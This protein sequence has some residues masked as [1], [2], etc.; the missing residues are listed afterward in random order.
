M[1]RD[2][3]CQ[4]NSCTVSHWLAGSGPWP[5]TRGRVVMAT[6]TLTVCIW[7]RPAHRAWTMAQNLYGPRVRMGNWN[8]DVYLEEVC[9]TWRGAPPRL[10]RD[11]TPTPTLSSPFSPAHTEYPYN[12]TPHRLLRNLTCGSSNPGLCPSILPGAPWAPKLG[13][14]ALKRR[15]ACASPQPRLWSHWVPSAL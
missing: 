13:A 7:G 3:H 12:P 10:L 5:I 11:S 15:W 1:E 2:S 4:G 14:S 8:E 9:R 6:G